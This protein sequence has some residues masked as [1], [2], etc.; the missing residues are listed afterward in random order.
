MNEAENTFRILKNETPLI[1]R[2]LCY[3][4]WHKY[5]LYSEPVTEKQG[6]WTVCVQKRRCV[7]CGI[8]QMK[9]LWER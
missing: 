5:T 8:H 7:G 6:A 1:T 9:T 2:F 4:G 3:V